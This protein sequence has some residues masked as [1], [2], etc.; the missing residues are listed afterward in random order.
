MNTSKYTL[1]YIDPRQCLPLE[2][3]EGI[4]SNFLE[5]LIDSRCRNIDLNQIACQ[6]MRARYVLTDIVVIF[7]AWLLQYTHC[8]V[9]LAP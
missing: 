2:L 3:P 1:V 6:S 4:R 5:M 9:K 8:A 7:E